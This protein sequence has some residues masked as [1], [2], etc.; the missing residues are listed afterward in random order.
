VEGAAR[1]TFIFDTSDG[2]KVANE[3]GASWWLVIGVREKNI[4]GVLD[5]TKD[6]KKAIWSLDGHNLHVVDLVRIIW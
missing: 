6:S 5:T 1:A 4:E 3:V 2:A